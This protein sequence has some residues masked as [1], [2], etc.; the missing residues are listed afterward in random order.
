MF[1]II[2]VSRDLIGGND[3]YHKRP[4]SWVRGVYIHHSATE[5][6]LGGEREDI[7]RIHNYHRNV[8]DWPG[9]GYHFVVAPTGN[10]YKVGQLSDIRYHTGG[11]DDPVTPQ[12]TSYHNEVGI[13]ICLIGD[14]TSEVPPA[15][16]RE[17]T[18]YLVHTLRGV[19]TRQLFAKGHRDV[20]A[21]ICPGDTWELWRQELESIPEDRM[22]EDV[23]RNALDVLWGTSKMLA[24]I[25]DVFKP[26]L[27]GDEWYSQQ[28][29]N[30]ITAI[31]AELQKAGVEL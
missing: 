23:L 6:A 31:K 30:A 15:V 8:H 2:D 10:I 22:D 5:P 20:G 17:A 18:A 14:F 12:A 1:S 19:F 16:Q 11:A 24:D 25:E 3:G 13:G 26:H 7:Q 21:T 27:R 4:L 9:I 28:A 29:Q